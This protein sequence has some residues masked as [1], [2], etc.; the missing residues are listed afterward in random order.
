MKKTIKA[1]ILLSFVLTFLLCIDLFNTDVINQRFIVYY[2]IN[3]LVLY[4]VA[5]VLYK[6]T[7]NKCNSNECVPVLRFRGVTCAGYTCLHCGEK[8]TEKY[9]KLIP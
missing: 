5:F 7:Y 4:S 8:W 1:L 3:L 9:K 6:R 2:V